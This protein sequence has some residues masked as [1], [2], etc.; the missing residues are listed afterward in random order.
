MGGFPRRRVIVFGRSMTQ[1]VNEGSRLSKLWNAT[2]WSA[3]S[4]M[5]MDHSFH[6]T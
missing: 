2:S 4:L 1:I 5:P 6:V 3:D